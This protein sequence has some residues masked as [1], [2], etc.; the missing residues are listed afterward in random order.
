MKTGFINKTTKKQGNYLFLLIALL[1]LIVIGPLLSEHFKIGSRFFLQATFAAVMFIGVWTLNAEHFWFR[2]G[3]GLAL[4]AFILAAVNYFLASKIIFLTGLMASFLFLIFSTYLAFNHILFSGKVTGNKIVGSLC[5]YLLIGVIWS[6]IYIFI[7]A[8][9]PD[10]FTNIPPFT[11]YS[12]MWEYLYFS[13]VT[14]TTLGYGDIS[15][16][17]PLAKTWAFLEAICGQFYLAILVASLV[18]TYISDHKK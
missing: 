7:A 8:T 16:A 10:A 4:T 13:F 12:H 14:L 11:E 18:G 1:A 17:I 5:I 9:H 6:L 2:V 3:I 15:P